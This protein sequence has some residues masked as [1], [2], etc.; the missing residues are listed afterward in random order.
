MP[1]E[2]VGGERS[3][4]GAAEGAQPGPGGAGGAREAP[5]R[6]EGCGPVQGSLGG[7]LQRAPGPGDVAVA[8]G[9][10][11]L[12][13]QHGAGRRRERAGGPRADRRAALPRVLHHQAAQHKGRQ[14]GGR[15]PD[16]GP[17][18][19]MCHAG[20]HL[21]PR[22]RGA[23]RDRLAA[24]AR[25]RPRAPHPPAAGLPAREASGPAHRG[26]LRRPGAGADAGAARAV[27]ARG[28]LRLRVDG[29]LA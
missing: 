20:G 6:A 13:R 26:R 29:A 12:P 23:G 10:R 27:G 28:C 19:G 3:P 16:G 22:V 11:E 1:G 21:R 24:V 25:R 14:G 8:R 15:G 5:A 9:G 17:G 7:L 2:C 4:G 18:R